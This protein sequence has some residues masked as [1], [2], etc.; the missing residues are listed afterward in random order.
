MAAAE[1]AFEFLERAGKAREKWEVVIIDPPSFAPSKQVRAG[2]G[3]TTVAP[4]EHTHVHTRTRTHTHTRA[5]SHKTYR[6]RHKVYYSVK[7]V[8]K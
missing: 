4:R 3:I 5:H 6:H 2:T 1:D 8:H 7:H